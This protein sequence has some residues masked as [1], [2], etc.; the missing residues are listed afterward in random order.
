V[1]GNEGYEGRGESNVRKNVNVL[2]IP[3]RTV[4]APQVPHELG[5]RSHLAKRAEQMTLMG[6]ELLTPVV[7]T[8]E[9]RSGAQSLAHLISCAYICLIT[10][11]QNIR[12]ALVR[13]VTAEP[14]PG[15]SVNNASP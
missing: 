2:R 15:A 5:T 6:A 11:A 12:N 4:E 3:R 10:L 7:R 8:V 13:W 14:E 1:Q 9:T